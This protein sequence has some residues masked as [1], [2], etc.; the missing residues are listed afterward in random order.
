[1]FVPSLIK[2]C[3]TVLE[4]LQTRRWYKA[5]CCYRTKKR[6]RL[7]LLRDALKHTFHV[8]M[9]KNSCFSSREKAGLWNNCLF[10]ESYETHKCTVWKKI[11]AFCKR[12]VGVTHSIHC[13]LKVESPKLSFVWGGWVGGSCSGM[14]PR[15][16]SQV[17][18]SRVLVF[19]RNRS[20]LLRRWSMKNS[21]LGAFAKSHY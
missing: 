18:R 2:I 4:W 19:S 16:L 15:T 5:A 8:H 13:A 7:L 3:Q 6:C 14:D 12:Q 17:V 10:Q 20:H 21:I 11:A 1:M 9:F